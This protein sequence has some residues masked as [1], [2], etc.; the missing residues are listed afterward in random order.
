MSASLVL[1]ID[2]DGKK[3][4]LEKPFSYP[5]H[6]NVNLLLSLLTSLSKINFKS[7]LITGI[8]LTSS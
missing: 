1:H 2:N 3:N 5:N 8:A 6:V 7:G 4:R